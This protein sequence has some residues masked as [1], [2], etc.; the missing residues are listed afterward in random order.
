MSD[1]PAFSDWTRPCH[2]VEVGRRNRGCAGVDATGK[3][4]RAGEGGRTGERGMQRRR[5]C[6]YRSGP[7]MACRRRLHRSGPCGPS[8]RRRG[9]AGVR[10]PPLGRKGRVTRLSSR[11]RGRL[12]TMRPSRTWKRWALPWPAI[13]SGSPSGIAGDVGTVEPFRIDE[14]YFNEPLPGW[15][16]RRWCWPTSGSHWLA[17]KVSAQP[18]PMR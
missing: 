8:L 10:A 2:A 13:S 5:A 1:A 16:N 17:S 6:G 14:G 7:R 12:A 15:R 18:A 3:E 11:Q 9:L 4:E